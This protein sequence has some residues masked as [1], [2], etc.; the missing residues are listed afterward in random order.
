MRPNFD[1][2]I[3]ITY[4]CSAH[5]INLLALDME[6]PNVKEQT[7]TVVKYLRENHLHLPNKEEGEI[8][9]CYVT[10]CGL[11]YHE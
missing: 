6:D 2:S 7:V 5:I 8:C 10:G 9:P 3:M 4:G 1:K 11:Q